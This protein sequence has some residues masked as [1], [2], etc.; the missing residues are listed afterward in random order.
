MNADLLRPF[1]ML[2]GA[3][4]EHVDCFRNRTQITQMNADEHCPFSGLMVLPQG[5]LT[6]G[7]IC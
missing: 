1:F 3:P 5:R 4:V 6:A 7:Y 2:D